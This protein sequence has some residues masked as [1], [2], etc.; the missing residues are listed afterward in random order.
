MRGRGGG[1]AADGLGN[2]G[3]PMRAVLYDSYGSPD[4]LRF[5]DVATPTPKDD[6]VLIRVLTTTVNRSDVGFRTANPWIVRLFSGLVR[7]K[8][9]ILGNEL[10][11]VIEGVGAR[12]SAFKVGDQVCGFTGDGFGAHAEYVCLSMD[13]AIVLIPPALRAEEACTIWDGPWLGLSCLRAAGVGTGTELLI[14]GASGSIGTSAVQ[15][16]RHLGAQITAVCGTK[17]LALVQS[18]GA[19]EV[20]DYTQTDFTKVGRTF[21]VVLDAVGKSSFGAC[22]GLVKPGG[23]YMSTDLGD[24]WQN[25]WLTLWTR[26]F[27]A[28]RVMLA[29]PDEKRARQDLQYLAELFEAKILRPVIDRTYPFEQIIEAHRYVDS[30]QKTGSVVIQIGS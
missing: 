14:Y 27:G 17:N 15:L 24:W 13:A 3:P 25:P 1:R 12:V 28:K 22:K 10:A 16:A 30:E 4:V 7:P 5:A 8:S 9:R 6:E 21:D 18:L 11:G 2:L 23:L 29:I 20:I 19:D 26:V